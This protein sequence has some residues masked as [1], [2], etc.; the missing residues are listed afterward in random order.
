MQIIF[1]D[2]KLGSNYIILNASLFLIMS[3][4]FP[5]ASIVEINQLSNLGPFLILLISII[6]NFN[7]IPQI[8]KEDYK[9]GTL[10]L[11]LIAKDS[12]NIILSK[13]TAHFLINI[14]SIL[15]IF[16]IIVIFYNLPTNIALITFLSLINLSLYSAF[17]CNLLSLIDLYFK[18]TNHLLMILIFPLLMPILILTSMVILNFQTNPTIL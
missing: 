11:L 4:I 12:Y 7:Y 3:S 13:V 9:D 14:L 17:I 2:F 16:P 15:L 18:Y 1:R 10:E 5:L 6:L 8:Y